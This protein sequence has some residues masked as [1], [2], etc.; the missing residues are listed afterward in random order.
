MKHTVDSLKKFTED[1]TLTIKPLIYIPVMLMMPLLAEAATIWNVGTPANAFTLPPA[2]KP[3]PDFGSIVNFDSL[4]ACATFPIPATGCTNVSGDTYLS[5]VTISSLDG[6]YVIPFS[7]QSAPNELYDNG[8][9]GSANLTISLAGAVNAMGVGIA[10]SD[11]DASGSPVNIFLQA[12]NSTGGNLGAVDEITLPE[13]G[14]NPGNG[15]FYVTDTTS[16]IFGIRITQSVGN[17]SL[18][19]GLA[20]DD[21]AV[22]PEPSTFLLLIGGGL[23]M[24]GSSRLR[25]RA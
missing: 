18:F 2:T 25:K 17:P 3:T 11:A 14:S 24:I 16:E 8:A 6:L 20:I 23:A 22:A 12:L 13:T 15:F 7:S 5:D 1:N 19:S 10:D 9:G 4:T 21:V